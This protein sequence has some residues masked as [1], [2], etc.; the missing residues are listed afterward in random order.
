M[1]SPSS[2]KHRDL[3]SLRMRNGQGHR[4][5]PQRRFFH[6]SAVWDPALNEIVM[7]NDLTGLGMRGRGLVM[8]EGGIVVD[9]MDGDGAMGAGMDVD[10]EDM[11][12]LQVEEDWRDTR[13]LQLSVMDA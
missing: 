11:V 7:R 2:S 3:D 13:D 12:Q 8:G 6:S 5:H 10:M 9:A 1:F 4:H